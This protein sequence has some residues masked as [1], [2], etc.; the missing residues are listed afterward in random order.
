MNSSSTSSARQRT[1]QRRSWHLSLPCSVVAGDEPLVGT[2]AQRRRAGALE[3]AP[4]ARWHERRFVSEARLS[5]APPSLNPPGRWRTRQGWPL[6]CQVWRVP[7]TLRWRYLGR[8][9]D[10][11][12]RARFCPH[13]E[14][15]PQRK[16]QNHQQHTDNEV[17]RPRQVRVEQR[18]SN[19]KGNHRR[20][21]GDRVVPKP[22]DV[23][24]DTEQLR[25]RPDDIQ[26]PWN[27]FRH[28]AQQFTRRT[29]FDATRPILR[30]HT[31]PGSG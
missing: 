25:V 16:K 28:A 27:R 7:T 20:Q 3:C 1:G 21:R 24:E 13:A 8:R 9:T 30:G 22:A 6:C 5:D 31:P 17:Y 10:V 18:Q 29:M 19:D 4:C 2:A 26:V 14:V 23:R 15:F 11:Q 12:R